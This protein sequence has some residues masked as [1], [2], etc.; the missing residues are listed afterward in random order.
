MNIRTARIIAA[1]SEG[2]PPPG[3]GGGGDNG[4]SQSQ[5]CT[6]GSLPVLTLPQHSDGWRD[7]NVNNCFRIR[8]TDRGREVHRA[9][10]DALFKCVPA[11]HSPSYL[12][13][14]ADADGWT[15]MQAWEVMQEFGQSI[16]LGGDVPFETTIQIEIP[17][18][19]NPSGRQTIMTHDPSKSLGERLADAIRAVGLRHGDDPPPWCDLEAQEQGQ[20]DEVAVTFTAS[21]SDAPQGWRPI[22]TAPHPHDPPFFAAVAVYTDGKF[23]RWDCHFIALDDE[24]G[25]VHPDYDQGWRLEDY[26]FWSPTPPPKDPTHDQ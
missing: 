3:G 23:L 25:D 6:N 24:T 26:D 11:R 8:L 12:A 15:K 9:N 18:T 7:F 17:A 19:P 13:P 1:R 21:L 10:H 5:P 22:E 20:L 16:R 2:L 4:L 14:V